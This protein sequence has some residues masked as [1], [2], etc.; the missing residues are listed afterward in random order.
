MSIHPSLKHIYGNYMGLI[1]EA[2]LSSMKDT[3]QSILGDVFYWEV[4]ALIFYIILLIIAR[5]MKSK[6][7]TFKSE[8]DEENHRKG[9]ARSLKKILG[10][11]LKRTRKDVER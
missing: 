10:N 7:L 11:Y 6:L 3:M 1:S 9:I 2:K 5:Y 8:T 4:I